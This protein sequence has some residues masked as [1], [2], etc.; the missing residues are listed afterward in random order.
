MRAPLP[1]CVHVPPNPLLRL[2]QKPAAAGLGR[3]GRR[4]GCVGVERP[5]LQTV[6]VAVGTV[7]VLLVWWLCGMVVRTE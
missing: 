7:D 5:L 3:H 1:I 6:N 4:H 2:P